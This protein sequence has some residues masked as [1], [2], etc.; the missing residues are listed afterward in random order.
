MCLIFSHNLRI[1]ISLNYICISKPITRHLRNGSILVGYGCSEMGGICCQ[2]ATNFKAVGR[3]TQGNALK[4]VDENCANLGVGEHGEVCLKSV[5]PILGYFNNEEATST[6]LINGWF[7]TGDIGY[8]NESGELYVVDRSKDIMK[9]DNYQ[10]NPSEI[11]SVI[12]EI[13]QVVLVSVF[14]VPHPI[15]SEVPTAMV[16]KSASATSEASL[17][18]KQI[19]M[20]VEKHLPEYKWL[21]GGVYFVDQMPTTASGKIIKRMCKEWVMNRAVDR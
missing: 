1:L 13:P 16:I 8:V 4:I 20:Y 2:T 18:E 19:E 12:G 21:K 3:L 9:V 7:H 6:S 14:G 11:E 10:V 5:L 15:H 17:T